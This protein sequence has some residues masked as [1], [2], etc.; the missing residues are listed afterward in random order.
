MRKLCL[1][2]K[3][4]F[5]TSYHT[6]FPEY[7]HAR[8]RLPTAITYA[9]L[10]HFHAPSTATMVATPAIHEDLERRG[11]KR[12]VRWSR[13]VDSTLFRPGT[14]TPNAWKRP[15]FMYVGASQSERTS[16][17]SVARPC[18]EPRSSWAT[19]RIGRLLERSHRDAVFVGR[20]G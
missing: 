13:G 17:R 18:P 9:W 10:R 2:G 6:R 4:P 16:A 20:S 14:P 5:T 19:D 7:V 3:I 11:F 1:R 15:V 12:L 8:T